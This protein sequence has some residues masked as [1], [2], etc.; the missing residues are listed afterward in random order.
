MRKLDKGFWML[1]F[2]GTYGSLCRG[3]QD[4]GLRQKTIRIVSSKDVRSLQ[5]T[6]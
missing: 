4:R 1:A 2:S 3:H 5:F 6:D